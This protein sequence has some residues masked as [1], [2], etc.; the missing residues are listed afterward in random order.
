[1]KLEEVVKIYKH[2]V[3]AMSLKRSREIWNRQGE[4]VIRTNEFI[5]P[6]IKKG[7]GSFV[8]DVDG[9]KYLDLNGGQFCLCFGHGYASLN[10]V[11][12]NQLETIVHTNTNSLSNIVFDALQELIKITNQK[13][14]SG[15]LLSTG[16]EAVEFALRF[17]KAIS[18]NEKIIF[19]NEGYHGLSLG[20]QS[21]S[22]GGKWAFPK[23]K[24]SF[25][26]TIPKS[27]GE[28]DASVKMV[29]RIIN[30]NPD[31]I[32][33]IIIE[34]VLGAGGMIFPPIRFFKE[35]RALCDKYGIMLI[36]DE[37]QTGFGRTGSWFCFQKYIISPD[38]LIFA[39]AAGAGLP[40]S[41]VL[42][43]KRLT[44]K[45]R[46]CSLTHFS[47][48]QNDPLAAAILLFVIKEI[49][50]NKLLSKIQ[51][52]GKVLLKKITKIAQDNK[53][54][55]NPRGIG[56]MIAFD[57][58][59]NLYTTDYNPGIILVN[60]LLIRG[61]IIQSI[62][63]G[64]TFRVLPNFLISPKEIKFFIDNLKAALLE[65]SYE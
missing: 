1:M 65:I 27:F 59:E 8:W 36:F 2:E 64:R 44:E 23:I 9:N 35:L 17:S 18:K 40:V 31:G 46:E 51:N 30:E 38:M 20:A 61:I 7:K 37:C 33:A 21:V 49:K 14:Q 3:N 58:N 29:K 62:N 56:L 57:L 26:F 13:F 12:I 5:E 45:M 43:N 19:A 6:V 63:H 50:E 25:G 15:I 11:I 47:S 10:S 48:H 34:P 60:K 42:F 53:V 28:V 52:S 55:V 54:L 24:E 16:A 41:G 32:A 39:K 4:F 22:T